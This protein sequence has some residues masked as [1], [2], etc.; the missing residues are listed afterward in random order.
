MHK[1]NVRMELSV[2]LDSIP[3]PTK[4]IILLI[5]QIIWEGPS[6]CLP[7]DFELFSFLAKCIRHYQ[8]EC[9][10]VIFAEMTEGKA[11]KQFSSNQ[12]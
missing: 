10:R 5:K 4:I 6:I 11:P 2:V 1:H 7:F 9:I 3:F 8:F 12:N